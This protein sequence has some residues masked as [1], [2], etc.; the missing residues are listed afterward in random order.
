MPVYGAKTCVL[1]SLALIARKILAG[2]QGEV[3]P[4]LALRSVA[5]L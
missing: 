1:T 3:T 2:S 4:K 5:A